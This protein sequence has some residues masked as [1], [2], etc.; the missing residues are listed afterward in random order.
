MSSWSDYN[1]STLEN[2]LAEVLDEFDPASPEAGIARQLIH[3]PN[4]SALSVAQAALYLRVIVPAVRRLY[5]RRDRQ[6]RAE[7]LDREEKNG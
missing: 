1:S 7:M 4:A 5:D 3:D 6:H 2:D